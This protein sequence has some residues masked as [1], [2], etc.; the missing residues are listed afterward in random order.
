MYK[1]L[2]NKGFWIIN[3]I[4]LVIIYPVS[5]FAQE[6]EKPKIPDIKTLPRP[7]VENVGEVSTYLQR[8]FLPRI[9]LTI[10]SIAIGVSVIMIIFGAIQMLTAYGDTEKYSNAKKTILFSILGLAIAL[11]SYAIVQVIFYTAYNI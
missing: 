5:V 3:A 11:L 10:V 6:T 7:N 4:T 8:G 1:R 9:A 2:I